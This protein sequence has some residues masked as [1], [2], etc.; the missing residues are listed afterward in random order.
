MG[1]TPTYAY[2]KN[3]VS[4]SGSYKISKNKEF[5]IDCNDC[6]NISLTEAAQNKQIIKGRHFCKIYRSECCHP[7]LKGLDAQ[8]RP[9]PECFRDSHRYFSNKKQFY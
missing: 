5:F 8:I 9:C 2:R 1:V 6:R 4:S 3:M 7:S